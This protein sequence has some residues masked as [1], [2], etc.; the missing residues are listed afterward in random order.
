MVESL[1][2]GE[3]S[4]EKCGEGEEEVFHDRDS[5]FLQCHVCDRCPLTRR[6]AAGE[7]PVFQ[8]CSTF[9]YAGVL[10]GETTS[11]TA[12]PRTVKKLPSPRVQ[13]FIAFA[14]ASLPTVAVERL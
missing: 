11:E 2:R 14:T 3:G 13:S 6:E 8:W 12:F 7:G 1:R 5:W 4:E 9:G 10:S